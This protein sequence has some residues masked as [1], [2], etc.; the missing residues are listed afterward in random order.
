MRSKERRYTDVRRLYYLRFPDHISR[1]AC[2]QQRL[3]I[4]AQVL[5]RLW[6]SF[7]AQSGI[8]AWEV[9]GCSHGRLSS[10]PL[11]FELAHCRPPVPSVAPFSSVPYNA[12]PRKQHRASRKAASSSCRRSMFSLVLC[13]SRTSAIGRPLYRLQSTV[14]LPFFSSR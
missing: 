13:L 2:V 14:S 6:M 10:C 11:P 3:T 8:I 4:A 12:M 9:P 7:T 5:C 1:H